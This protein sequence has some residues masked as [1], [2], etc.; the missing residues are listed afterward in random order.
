MRLFEISQ[1]GQTP[2]EALREYS[3]DPQVYISFTSDVG[4]DSHQTAVGD[5]YVPG[6]N[7][8]GAKLGVNANSP[9]DTPLGIYA[10]PLATIWPEIEAAGSVRAVPFA[11]DQPYIHVLR[12]TG[13]ESALL[14][15]AG[16]TAG[17]LE[18]DMATL[19]RLYGEQ[20]FYAKAERDAFV[21]REP[22]MDEDPESVAAF[23]L[24][25]WKLWNLTGRIAHEL[26]YNNTVQ[27]VSHHRVV[28]REQTYALASGSKALK[29]NTVLRQLG[30]SGAVDR[31]GQGVIHPN[32][33]VQAVF[34]TKPVIAVVEVIRNRRPNGGLI[35]SLKR[36][37]A[38]P[39]ALRQAGSRLSAAD[40]L[41][42]LRNTT[43]YY[44]PQFLT[45]I[46]AAVL[47]E[48]VKADPDI[49]RGVA[50]L[51]LG[52]SVWQRLPQPALDAIGRA[53]LAHRPMEDQ[54]DFIMAAFPGLSPDIPAAFLDQ[55]RAA[56]GQPAAKY[57]LSF[58]QGKFGTTP[59]YAA[60][61]DHLGRA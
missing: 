23:R 15:I 46:P 40:W 27:R 48:V 39:Q 52:G 18:R 29:W 4:Q 34:L 45:H 25:V 37:D 30:Y 28:G 26:A 13:P 41:E 8:Q 38:S 33:P 3:T 59:A 14:E 12:Y 22:E 10:Y 19:R 6:R 49:V 50:S 5:D 42:V 21:E 1:P 24:P 61:V 35:H 43:P 53:V 55:Q 2:L 31:E 54:F 60:L 44:Y 9:W 58:L 36:Y 16:Y 32:E 57:L 11:G 20:P 7:I 47:A 17:D 56:D 51:R